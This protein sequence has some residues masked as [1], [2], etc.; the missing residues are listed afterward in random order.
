M[1]TMKAPAMH[2]AG[3]AD[4]RLPTAT[5]H[6]SPSL[7]F[8]LPFPSLLSLP[9]LPS[10]KAAVKALKL[11]GARERCTDNDNGNG[12]INGNA[13]GVNSGGSNSSSSSSSN[14]GPNIN[15]Q[16]VSQRWSPHLV[17]GLQGLT[18]EVVTAGLSMSAVV[19]FDRLRYQQLNDRGR[20]SPRPGHVSNQVLYND[21]S[22][23]IQYSSD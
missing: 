14:A 9:P 16:H 21:E 23:Y 15:V 2:M 3:T 11:D 1:T 6:L 13:I 8:S 20:L 7:T 22:V 17:H 10:I 12:S 4:D 5:H 18:V 19:A